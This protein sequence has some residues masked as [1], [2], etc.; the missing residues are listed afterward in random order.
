MRHSM[1][2]DTAFNGETTP[3]H[4]YISLWP[5]AMFAPLAIPESYAQ[6]TRKLFILAPVQEPGWTH[7][8]VTRAGIDFVVVSCKQI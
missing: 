2:E 3:R 5:L 4:I 8:G 7:A 6:N 1:S